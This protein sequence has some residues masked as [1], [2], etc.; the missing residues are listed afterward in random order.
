MNKRLLLSLA[1]GLS[2]VSSFAYEVGEYIF[3]ADAKYKV[4]GE[5]LIAN[6]KFNTNYS[7]W[8]NL[9]GS[10]VSTDFWSIETGVGPAG[11]NA[12]QCTNNA[13]GNDGAYVFQSVPYEANKT[14]VVS[15]KVYA[16][17]SVTTSTDPKSQNYLDV[18][19]NGDFSSSKSATGFKQVA[20]TTG[21]PANRWI[22]V[23]FSFTDDV[24]GGS[25]GGIA[26]AL[27]RMEPGT[28][29]TDV[30]V[31]EVLQ[32]YD[33]RI[34]ERKL[35]YDKK[36]LA[37]TEFP[38]GKD[39]LQ[40]IVDQLQAC[41]DANSGE[42]MGVNFDDMNA[43]NDFVSSMSMIEAE[44]MNANS[45]DLIA[46][47]RITGPGL[48]VNKL[49]KG[50]GNYGDWYVGGSS[51]WFHNDKS[52]EINSSLPS[53]F[54]LNAGYMGIRKALPAGKYMF[55]VDVK[56]NT[57]KKGKDSSGN[58]TIM[59]YETPVTNRLFIGTDTTAAEVLSP[60]EFHTYFIIAD[61]PAGTTPEELNLMAG[62]Q[63]SAQSLGGAFY[64][65]NPVLRYIS[66]TAEQDIHKFVADNNKAA[67]M[68]AAKVMIDSAKVVQPKAEFP[69][70]KATLQSGIAVCEANYDVLKATASTVLLDAASGDGTT[71]TVADSL[72]EVMRNMRGYIQAYYAENTPYTDLVAAVNDARTVFADTRYAG[73]TAATKGALKAAID[74]ADACIAAFK[75]RNDSLEGD[76]AKSVALAAELSKSKI[77]FMS[78][79][80]SFEKPAEVDIIN[81]FFAEY[82]AWNRVNGWD[83]SGS[84]SD[85]GR[86]KGAANVHGYENGTALN[87]QR[88]YTAFSKN[89]VVQTVTLT[90]SGIYEFACQANAYNERGSYDGDRNQPS[91]IF[92]F[93]KNTE[94]ADS[95][96]AIMIHTDRANM[97][98]NTTDAN[99]W[100]NGYPEYFTVVYKKTTDT[101]ETIQ[102]G[103]DALQN[104]QCNTY[105]F[106]GNHIRFM[107]E[108]AKYAAAL[109]SNVEAR[110]ATAKATLAGITDST[111][112]TVVSDGLNYKQIY[113]TLK[114]AVGQG[115]AAL[116]MSGDAAL[117][118][119]SKSYYDLIKAVENAQV[120]ATAIAGVNVNESA[121]AAV[122]Q[123]VYNMAGQKIADNMEGLAKGLYIVNGR[124][125]VVK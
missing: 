88:G 122:A 30:V 61:V 117:N 70:G 52:D 6:G 101:P 17:S 92:Y 56:G 69:W 15:M 66:P 40:G 109:R 110:L 86:W 5:N 105:R 1:V 77:A 4:V 10:A 14:Y 115:E 79:V 104:V 62:A 76:A 85:N 65:K 23:S 51:R 57:Y 7:N 118:A 84:Q 74:Q 55:Q 73:A 103:F 119:Q 90:T 25:V 22:D 59:D 39:D 50:N 116:A 16:P 41:L 37:L 120:V 60:R 125:V 96:G 2:A 29:V 43:M 63:H 102:F 12:L 98:D 89:K 71:V 64:Y 33:T 75:A 46:G 87:M 26:V 123:G 112:T 114:Y 42:A 18:F 99:S 106:G 81:P 49:Q 21:I 94:S 8:T 78:S 48:W 44:Y 83:T 38:N 47:G 68:N 3:T 108:P 72:M 80:A 113:N 93:V 27:G 107:G 32:V 67:Q 95:I 53:T 45:Y 19:V 100:G 111:T 91:Q 13:D 54:P 35:A 36:I 121:K 124:K 9:A 28:Q 31:H 82:S 11:E 97:C 58:F 34:L 24:E 20:T